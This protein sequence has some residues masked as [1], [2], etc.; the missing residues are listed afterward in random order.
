MISSGARMQ[1]V[2]IAEPKM[3]GAREPVSARELANVSSRAPYRKAPTR[4]GVALP[5]AIMGFI[6]SCAALPLASISYSRGES[7]GSRLALM[8]AGPT[9]FDAWTNAWE[10][11]PESLWMDIT[12]DDIEFTIPK[13]GASFSGKDNLWEFRKYL[14]NGSFA[15][16]DWTN[17]YSSHLQDRDDPNVLYVTMTSYTRYP[18]YFG[19]E[20]GTIFQIGRWTATFNDD[21]KI[22][23]MNQ[24]VLYAVYWNASIPGQADPCSATPPPSTI[25]VT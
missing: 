18:G 24:D 7:N 19:I 11:G 21:G 17:T 13:L 22:K 8:I 1:D 4:G 2:K 9:G 3:I 15:Q 12:A 25:C 23:A 10:Y 14:S 6:L 20:P 16:L 5:L